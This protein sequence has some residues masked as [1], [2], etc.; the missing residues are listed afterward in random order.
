MEKELQTINENPKRFQKG[1]GLAI[2]HNILVIILAIMLFIAFSHYSI[3]LGIIW[4]VCRIGEGSILSYN[5]KHYL[6]FLGLAEKYSCSNDDE[7]KSIIDLAFNLNNEKRSRFSLA[8]IFWAI[9]TLAF[10]IMLVVYGVV[11][12]FIGAMGIGSSIAVGI[13]DGIKTVKYDYKPAKISSS[14]GGAVALLF[15]II[16]GVWLIIFLT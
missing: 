12:L 7:K 10:S 2:I 9:G 3:M 14:V 13:G 11:P 4:M 1:I 15:E 16:I 5:D 8:M 6:G